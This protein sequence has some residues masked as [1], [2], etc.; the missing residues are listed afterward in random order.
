MPG[1]RIAAAG[2]APGRRRNAQNVPEVRIAAQEQA[3]SLVVQGPPEAIALAEQ[4]IQRFD[5]EGAAETTIQVFPCTKADATSL[6]DAVNKAL[7]DQSGARGRATRPIRVR[8]RTPRWW[9][10][11]I[12]IRCSSAAARTRWPRPW[13]WLSNWTRAARRGAFGAGLY[14][15]VRPG[16]PGQQDHR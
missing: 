13:S 7:A 1:G 8:P 5:T 6:A 14:A 9:P 10:S 11:R 12:P 4:I 3:N 16:K 15:Q 2:R